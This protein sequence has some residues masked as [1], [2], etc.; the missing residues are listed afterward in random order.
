MKIAKVYIFGI[1]G[2]FF[3]PRKV[4]KFR[5]ENKFCLHNCVTSVGL[6]YLAQRAVQLY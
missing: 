4:I 5:Y 6:R 1:L 3:E 2:L